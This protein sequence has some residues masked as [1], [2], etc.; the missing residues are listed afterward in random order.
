MTT[1]HI[2]SPG[3]ISPESMGL[4]LIELKMYVSSE[5]LSTLKGLSMSQVRGKSQPIEDSSNHAI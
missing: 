2:M 5:Y 1:I 4:G 3:Q